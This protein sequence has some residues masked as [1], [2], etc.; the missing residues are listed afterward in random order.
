LKAFAFGLGLNEDAFAL[1]RAVLV[2]D[3]GTAA[4][5]VW[6]AVPCDGVGERFSP[7]NGGIGWIYMLTVGFLTSSA[8]FVVRGLEV[9]VEAPAMGA[10][11]TVGTTGL[12]RAAATLTDVGAI[13]EALGEGLRT[14]VTPMARAFEEEASCDAFSRI[15]RCLSSSL[16]RIGTKSSGMVWFN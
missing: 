2:G 14:V 8:G 12:A 10:F 7:L 13:R 3:M 9:E 16:A 11:V 6:V 4:P 15:C 5:F 1:S